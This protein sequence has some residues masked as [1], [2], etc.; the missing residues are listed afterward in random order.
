[1]IEG[2]LEGFD[3][4]LMHAVEE[5]IGL[6]L[7]EKQ[8]MQVELR[9]G[10]SGLGLRLG[11]SVAD[12]AYVSSRAMTFEVCEELDTDFA[13]DATGGPGAEDTDMGVG[14]RR[15]WRADWQERSQG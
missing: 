1:M 3:I 13:W 9:V 10:D 14:G 12:G 15:K 5:V 7:E 2:L 11:K 4:S 8:R 6:R